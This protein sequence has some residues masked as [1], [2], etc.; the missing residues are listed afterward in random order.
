[1]NPND[2]MYYLNGPDEFVNPNEE[3]DRRGWPEEEDVQKNN[4]PTKWAHE[5]NPNESTSAPV[6]KPM[7]TAK[8]VMYEK[9][10]VSNKVDMM[11]N[12]FIGLADQGKIVIAMHEYADQQVAALQEENARLRS[13]IEKFTNIARSYQGTIFANR[14]IPQWKHTY[15]A[16]ESVIEE[17]REQFK[18]DN[19]L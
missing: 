19:N 18:K 8:D 13:L 12:Q 3:D 17:A 9:F 14:D 7:K 4:P 1:M 10:G 11:K 15:E 6:E 16:I 5:M 2:E